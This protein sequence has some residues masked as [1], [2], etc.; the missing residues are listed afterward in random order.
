M[1]ATASFNFDDGMATSSWN[2]TFAFR[3]RVN[4]SAIGS[5]IVTARSPPSPRA[6]R[7]ARDL[8]GMSHLAQ[9]EP[10]QP[11]VAVDRARPATPP[12]TR[13]AAHLELRRALLLVH[14]CLLGHRFTPAHRGGT[15]TRAHAGAHA[16][17]RRF[18]LWSRSLRSC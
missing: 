3:I 12:T 1:T 11:E 2:A 8:T 15:G 16:P 17:A 6:L 13:V 18:P 5:V 14:E 10:A 4:M 9:T 7:H